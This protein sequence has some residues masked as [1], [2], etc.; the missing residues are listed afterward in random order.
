[1][2][3][4]K[5]E[6]SITTGT[7]FNL[8]SGEMTD[9]IYQF[10]V[11]CNDSA[12]RRVNVSPTNLL[13]TI[14][15][16]S[17]PDISI[18]STWHQTNG[19]D[20]TPILSWNGTADT[21][22]DKY[23]VEARNKSGGGLDFQVNITDVDTTY[24]EL[25]LTVGN[26]YN[27]SVTAYDLAGNTAKTSNTTDT[28]FYFDSVCSTLYAG[29]N[30]C[31]TVRTTSS[32]LSVLGA[33]MGATM[34]AI[35]NLSHQWE[36]CVVGVSATNC[37]EEY[38]TLNYTAAWFY[39][40]SDTLWENRTWSATK[41]STNVTL[42]NTTNPWNLMGMYVRNGLTFGELNDTSLG[43]DTNNSA[44]SWYNNS[45]GIYVPYI[46]IGAFSSINKNHDVPYGTAFWV[47]HMNVT[48]EIYDV[49]GW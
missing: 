46:M 4:N 48:A 15:T 25:D 41:L 29:W 34:V 22:F 6:I 24:A 11:E 38:G 44:M 14:D 1:M 33:E 40:S 16:T 31:G 2:S 35:W 13:V 8:T 12:N 17:P 5:T 30:L 49:G 18:N 9:G 28:L 7:Q 39:V 36:T 43:D 45:A 37:Q 3:I 10:N 26:T 23:V 20:G 27:F 21:N 42:T 19:T 47:H 32:N